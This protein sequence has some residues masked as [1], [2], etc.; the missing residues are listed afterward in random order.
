LMAEM[1][2]AL[3]RASSAGPAR[4]VGTNAETNTALPHSWTLTVR[5]KASRQL[6]YATLEADDLGLMLLA[7]LVSK[8]PPSAN[9]L[10]LDHV[11]V[12]VRAVI[13]HTDV[14]AA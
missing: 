10:A 14:P 8:A 4:V 2:G 5:A 9:T 11:P 1:L 6:R 12:S 3:D 7:A 13:G